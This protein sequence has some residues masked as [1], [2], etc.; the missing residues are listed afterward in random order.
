MEVIVQARSMAETVLGHEQTE[1]PEV[2]SPCL[3]G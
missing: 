2:Y 1:T 3:G